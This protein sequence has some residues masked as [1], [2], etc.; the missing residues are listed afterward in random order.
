MIKKICGLLS[1][2]LVTTLFSCSN[3]S[4]S[5]NT[6]PT[7]SSSITAKI[8]GVEWASM[9]GGA[10]ANLS[11]MN[12][13]GESLNMLQ[14]MGIKADESNLTINFP[15]DN[16]AV[17]TYTFDSDSDGTLTFSTGDTNISD[18]HTSFF[19]TGN[20][21]V[22]ISEI[23]LTAGT[24][25]G[26]FSGTIF[27]A[28]GDSMSITNG[29]INSVSIMSTDFYSNGTMSLSRNGGT[30]F[31]MDNN[32]SDGKYLMIMQNSM[33]QS[34]TL[35]G[36]NTVLNA[37]AG[38]Y[39][40]TFPKNVTAGTYNLLTTDGFDANIGTSEGQAE[41]SLTGGTATIT[42]H[43]GNNVVGTFSFTVSNGSQTVTITNG[44]FSIT[45]N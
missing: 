8:D 36:Y 11:Q 37:D 44:S 16:L 7:S 31:T 39:S 20:F 9:N 22:T 2:V 14:I 33:S 35:A 28:N 15:V 26:T 43:N 45:H 30:A 17:G 3:D 42:S 18:T 40:L 41:F 5:D 4:D 23:N 10:V 12:V 27:D 29:A 13:M 19:H 34:V 24:I 32:Q 25:S 21:S 1:L 38:I 6:Q